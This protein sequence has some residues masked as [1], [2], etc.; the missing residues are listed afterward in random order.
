M[1]PAYVDAEARADY[2]AAASD[3]AVVHAMCED[4]R[5]GA[6]FDWSLDAADRGRRSITCPT[7]VLWGEHGALSPWFDVLETWH[8]WAEDLHGW[9]IADS[10]HFFPEERP[11]ET[12]AALREFFR[13]GS[14]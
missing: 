4:Y 13:P 1:N 8:V 6:G 3:P 11:A 2:L 14:A 10:G 12:S 7:L 9:Q 5:A